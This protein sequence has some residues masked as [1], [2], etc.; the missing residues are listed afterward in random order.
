M[1]CWHYKDQSPLICPFLY[2]DKPDILVDFICSTYY[3]WTFI[4]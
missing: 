1:P 2:M 4:I 3:N